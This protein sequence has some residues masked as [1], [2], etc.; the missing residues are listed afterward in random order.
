MF[1]F[2]Q[3]V[4]KGLLAQTHA[5]QNYVCDKKKM[6]LKKIGNKSKVEQNIVNRMYNSF[7]FYEPTQQSCVPQFSTPI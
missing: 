6:C 4:H 3:N 7:Y 5:G 1:L 2:R